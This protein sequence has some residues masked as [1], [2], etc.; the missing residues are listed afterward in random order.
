MPPSF[1]SLGSSGSLPAHPLLMLWV[2][3]FPAQ[4]QHSPIVI[5]SWPWKPL[6]GLNVGNN[7]NIPNLLCALV[8]NQVFCYPQSS[9]SHSP[10]SSL[11]TSVSKQPAKAMVLLG[12][13]WTSKHK[14]SPLLDFPPLTSLNQTNIPYNFFV[15]DISTVANQ[16]FHYSCFWLVRTLLLSPSFVYVYSIFFVHQRK[17]KHSPLYISFRLLCFPSSLF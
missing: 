17:K 2:A 14:N 13:W 10:S 5:N 16:L 15:F 12:P 8:S 1:S 6:H 7:D 3:G 4:I 9:S 11:P